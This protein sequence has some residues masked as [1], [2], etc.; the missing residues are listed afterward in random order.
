[1]D[2]KPESLNINCSADEVAE[3]ID[4][5]YSWIDTRGT[6]EKAL[7][8]TFRSAVGK[9]AFTLLRTLVYHKTLRGASIAEIQEALLRHVGSAQFETVGEK[10]N[11]A[12]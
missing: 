10:D 3:Y 6:T 9:E 8:G 7:K 5:F 4:R 1:M 11:H 12:A 2:P